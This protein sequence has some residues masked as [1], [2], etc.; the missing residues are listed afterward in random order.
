V[1]S[2]L[3]VAPIPEIRSNEAPG[4]VDKKQQEREDIILRSC[5][6]SIHAEAPPTEEEV[7][8]HGTDEAGAL[9]FYHTGKYGGIREGDV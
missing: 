7:S 4:F 6:R 5:P 9:R 1:A 2:C 3:R 8:D